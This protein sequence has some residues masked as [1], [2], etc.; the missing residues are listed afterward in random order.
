MVFFMTTSPWIQTALTA[1]SGALRPPARDYILLLIF[2]S[3]FCLMPYGY[4]FLFLIKQKEK[5]ARDHPAYKLTR[6]TKKR[7]LVLGV[8]N[9]ILKDDGLGVRTAEFFERAYSFGNDVSCIDGGTAGAGLLSLFGEFSHI[10]IIDAISSDSSPGTIYAFSGEALKKNGA[11]LKTSAHSIGVKDLLDL[12]AF[13]G[14]HPAVSIIGMVPSDV[15][16]GLEL[17]DAVSERLPDAAKLIAD[18]LKRNGFKA[19]KRKGKDA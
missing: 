2:F 13:E 10:I 6:K 17:S 4:I 9:I 16:P 11:L 5:T 19:A 14:S 8:G 7:A 18:E 15:S 3:T 12:A 1:S